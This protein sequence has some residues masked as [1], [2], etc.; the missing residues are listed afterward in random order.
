MKKIL[1]RRDPGSVSIFLSESDDTHINPSM[2]S[3]DLDA[4]SWAAGRSWRSNAVSVCMAGRR[5]S[6]S[7]EHHSLRH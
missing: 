1:S 2:A 4:A 5:P 6:T 3:F 7:Q